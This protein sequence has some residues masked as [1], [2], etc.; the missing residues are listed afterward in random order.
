VEEGSKKVSCITLDTYL[1]LDGINSV[2]LLKLDVE[3]FELSVLRGAKQSL[4]TRKI[5]A[6]YFEYFEK[7]LSR[8]GPSDEL[9]SFLD[10]VGYQVCF[11]R[12]FDL[13]SRGGPFHTLRTGLHGHG[14]PLMPVKGKTLPPMTDL[15][16]IPSENLFSLR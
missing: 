5:Q 13:K 9:L 3:G 8:V 11:C 15:L 1:G 7:W 14:L 2:N 4:E 12:A 10:A 6:I 16:A